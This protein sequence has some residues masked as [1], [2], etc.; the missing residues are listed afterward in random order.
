[1]LKDRK[2]GDAKVKRRVEDCEIYREMVYLLWEIIVLLILLIVTIHC[3]LNTYLALNSH[4]AFIIPFH[5]T[6]EGIV[7]VPSYRWGNWGSEKISDSA[8]I[9]ATNGKTW[10]HA[11]VWLN[12]KLA[13][14]VWLQTPVLAPLLPN[15]VGSWAHLSIPFCFFS[16]SRMILWLIGSACDGHRE[17]HEERNNNTCASPCLR[18]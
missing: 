3:A 11:H 1:M 2:D 15:L 7:W 8:D 9:Q 13:T 14:S 4:T 16:C 5:P 18:D 10:I 12:L 17:W 6:C